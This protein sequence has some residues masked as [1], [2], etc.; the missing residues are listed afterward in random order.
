M[1][2][3]RKGMYKIL[4]VSFIYSTFQN[5]VGAKKARE[6]IVKD[7]LQINSEMSLLDVG[8]GPGDILEFLPEGIDY[9]GIDS[10]A[11]Y[12]KA[13]EKKYPNARF[14]C[15]NVA[16]LSARQEFK[17]DRIFMSGLLH[18]L[19]DAEVIK[20][21]IDTRKLLNKNGALICIENVYVSEQSKVA[22]FIISKDRGQNT[23]TPEGYSKLIGESFNKVDYK[24]RHDL[25]NIPYTH[26][27]FRCE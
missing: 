27:I 19:E 22:R 14:F 26:I 10:E 24:I 17:F 11:S 18:H 20:L 8:C 1:G 2:Q 16:N 6:L 12:I 4:E 5:F 21:M 15:E 25:L 7:Y 3:I 13:A 9:I 23:R